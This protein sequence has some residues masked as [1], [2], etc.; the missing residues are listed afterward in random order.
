MSYKND[1]FIESTNIFESIILCITPKNTYCLHGQF[2][3]GY[4]Q[5]FHKFYRFLSDWRVL[6]G[7]VG[8]LLQALAIWTHKIPHKGSLNMLPSIE[9]EM[10]ASDISPS[11]LWFLYDQMC[12]QEK[13]IPDW[14]FTPGRSGNDQEAM[15][16]MSSE[17]I[18][19]SHWCYGE[20]ETGKVTHA[21]LNLPG[22]VA[23]DRS[24]GNK[25]KVIMWI[26]T[27]LPP[28]FI[29]LRLFFKKSKLDEK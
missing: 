24:L 12:N 6:F 3:S 9:V 7:A 13:K 18:R 29:E 4:R 10:L 8:L 16:G 26:S 19:Q 2:S 1:C 22:S 21:A 25:S 28:I 14:S 23:G 11:T 5:I 27:E 15:P 17:Q 20:Q